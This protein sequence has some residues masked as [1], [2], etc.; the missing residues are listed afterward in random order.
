MNP[1]LKQLEDIF[2]PG[3]DPAKPNYVPEQQLEENIYRKT[4]LSSAGLFVQKN[5]NIAP[6]FREYTEQKRQVQ[7]RI[8][9]DK[10]TIA[11]EK[12]ED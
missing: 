7:N 10:Q 6:Y 12:R 1:D 2:V 9:Q 11:K 8:N 5:Q 4:E 3:A